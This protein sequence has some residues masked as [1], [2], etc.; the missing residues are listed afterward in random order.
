MASPMICPAPHLIE[1]LGPSNSTIR[2]PG[3]SGSSSHVAHEVLQ[4]RCS[5]ESDT[6]FAAA[7]NTLSIDEGH[8]I[9]PTPERVVRADAED[10]DDAAHAVPPG[11][12]RAELAG[13][14]RPPR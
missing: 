4:E 12:I 3:P 13:P 1:I 9:D 14:A 2:N 10:H 7:M 8:A 6:C 5:T 11:H